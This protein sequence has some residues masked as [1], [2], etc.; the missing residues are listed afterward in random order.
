MDIAVKGVEVRVVADSSELWFDA[1]WSK[2]TLL[3]AVE[4]W[5]RSKGSGSSDAVLWLDTKS[6]S[7]E[8]KPGS[9]PGRSAQSEPAS[10][11][12]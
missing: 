10:A 2:W 7:S 1:A 5:C 9:E 6:S 11:M 3:N 4:R 8:D 12:R